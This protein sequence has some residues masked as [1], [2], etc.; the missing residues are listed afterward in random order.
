M[1]LNAGFWNEKVEKAIKHIGQ[2]C[3]DQQKN[4]VKK[5]VKIASWI[6]KQT[7]PDE[8]PGFL[9]SSYSG[10]ERAL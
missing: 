4:A 10:S 3:V 8:T 1:R 7:L 2:L 9:F 5:I 6:T